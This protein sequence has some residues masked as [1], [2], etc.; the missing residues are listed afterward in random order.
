MN[1]GA[2]LFLGAAWV[3]LAR[4]CSGHRVSS[5]CPPRGIT[6]FPLECYL[7]LLG[8]VCSSLLEATLSQSPPVFV[9]RYV[10]VLVVHQ[11]CFLGPFS[12]PMFSGC[13]IMPFCCSINLQSI[14]TRTGVSKRHFNFRG[15]VGTQAV[16]AAI[17]TTRVLLL[18]HDSWTA[19]LLMHSAPLLSII[20]TNQRSRHSSDKAD[21]DT[22]ILHVSCAF[23]QVKLLCICYILSST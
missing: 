20:K 5:E 11:K 17:I 8:A 16:I 9:V 12:A 3:R 4:A 15:H 2:S 1:S 10:T 21:R 6:C 23:L 13:S 18:C 19:Y 14:Y 22:L 7:L